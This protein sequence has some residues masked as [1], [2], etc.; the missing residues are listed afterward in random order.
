MN[1]FKSHITLILALISILISIFLFRAFNKILKEYEKSIVNNYSIVIVSTSKIESLNIKEIS[2]IEPISIEQQ[3]NNLRKKFKNI[4]FNKINF[5]YFYKLKLSKMLSPKEIN[6]LKEKLK[7]KPY[8]KRILTHSS[9]Q[10]KIYNLL[11]LLNI[12]TK[13][14]M[15]ITGILGFL[16]ILKQL[17][18]WKLLHNERM[19][20]MELFGAPFW[21]RGAALFKI[22][23]FDSVISLLITFGI[24]Y[25]VT[26]SSLFTQIIQELNINFTID[27]IKEFLFLA[28]ISL[29]IAVISSIMVVVSQK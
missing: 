19:Y 26:N 17:E 29:S 3:I 6:R 22:A 25:Y 4:D 16:L 13:T 9:S 8:I 27:Y 10:T 15:G 28:L 1:Y 11:M 14:F 12:I 5:P 24:I 2:S 18:V 20:I 21:L 7:Q 23:L